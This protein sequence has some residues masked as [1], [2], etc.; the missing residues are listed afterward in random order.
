MRTAITKNKHSDSFFMTHFTIEDWRSLEKMKWTE[1]LGR[2]TLGTC[3]Q[4]PC[5]QTQHEKL[6]IYILDLRQAVGSGSV[7]SFLSRQRDPCSPL[8]QN[9][10]CPT[11]SLLL[12]ILPD[13]PAVTSPRWGTTDAE[14]KV[15]PPPPVG[16]QGYQRFPLSKYV[17]GRNI[18]LH[19]VPVYLPTQCLP[20]RSIQLHFCSKFLQ[21]STI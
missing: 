1:L 13:V 19:A 12:S 10:R 17:V 6:Y 5:Q 11:S 18:A 7:I 15:P 8:S 3:S 2:Q 16:D 20:S 21:S 9:N 14:I 4:K